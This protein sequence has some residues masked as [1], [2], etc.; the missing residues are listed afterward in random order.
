MRGGL[1]TQAKAEGM[2]EAQFDACVASTKEDDTINKVAEDGMTRYSINSTPSIVIDGVLVPGVAE[3][4]P[5]SK[6]LD[7]ALA[8]K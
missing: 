3:Y 6:A 8:K 7:A 2:S 1:L 5:L 4:G